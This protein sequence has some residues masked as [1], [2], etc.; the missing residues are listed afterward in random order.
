MRVRGFCKV[1][2]GLEGVFVI[3]ATVKHRRQ[4]CVG[5]TQEAKYT[6]IQSLF[7]QAFYRPKLSSQVNY[8]KSNI[9]WLQNV[10]VH[11]DKATT[12]QAVADII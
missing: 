12:K 1:V 9:V 10:S 5:L 6:I 4:G 11:S 7:T 2:K 3:F 8:W